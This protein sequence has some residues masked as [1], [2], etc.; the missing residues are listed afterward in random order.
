MA[1]NWDIFSDGNNN[2]S[3]QNNNTNQQSPY[4]QNI[5]THQPPSHNPR[6]PPYIAFPQNTPVSKTAPYPQPDNRRQTAFPQPSAFPKPS[7]IHPAGPHPG[8]K[9]NVSP[10]APDQH[11]LPHGLQN[12]QNCCNMNS[13]LQILHHIPLVDSVFLF[14][15]LLI[16][17][18]LHLAPALYTDGDTFIYAYSSNG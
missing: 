8:P 7:N 13:L 14:S 6:P 2:P 12:Y 10:P 15:L 1:E 11:R 16:K 3:Q 18:Y 4:Q 9:K 5:G 17:L